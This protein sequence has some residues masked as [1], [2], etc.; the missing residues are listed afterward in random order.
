L[1]RRG[2][3]GGYMYIL[4]CHDLDARHTQLGALGIR[5]VQDTRT[6]D[7][8]L[9]SRAIHLHPK[10]TGGCL[11]SID[12]HSGGTDTMGGYRWAGADWQSKVR[13]DVVISGAV[14]QC[15]D[16]AATAE[17]WARLLGRPAA[18]RADGGHELQLDNAVARFVPLADDRGEGLARV[19]LSCADPASLLAAATAT[20][21]PVGSSWIEVCGVRFELANRT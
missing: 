7:A 19:L 17:R 20:G 8:W 3:D 14:M 4:D 12:R 10:D 13:R 1:D 18:A 15:D 6:G 11:L 21:A 5:I 9:W 16:P 2:G